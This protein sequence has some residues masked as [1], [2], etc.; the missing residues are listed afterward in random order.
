MMGDEI[1]I[2][3]GLDAI[4]LRP[5]MYVGPVNTPSVFG[6]LIEQAMCA[7]LDDAVSGAC[8]KIVVR[9]C[10]DRAISV[11]DDGAGWP[12]EQTN[13]EGLPRPQ[14]LLTKLGVCRAQRKNAQ[15]AAE[16]CGLGIAVVN[17]LSATLRFE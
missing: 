11:E 3:A 6:E 10:A 1:K 17:A 16:F 9:L 7:A 2:L 5:E 15:I 14:V 8:T 12:V 4:R 13:Q